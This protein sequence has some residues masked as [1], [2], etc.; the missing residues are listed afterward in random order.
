MNRRQFLK[1]ALYGAGG[2]AIGVSGFGALTKVE[3]KS[4]IATTNTEETTVFSACEMC[5][6]QCPIAVKVVN[7]KV[8]KIEGNPNDSGFGGVI[9]AR[10]NSGPSLLYDP[11]RLKKPMIRTGERGTGKYKEVSWDEAYTYIAD[12]LKVI[13]QD[14]GGESV[15]FASRKG[16]HDWFFRTIGKGIG[17]PNIFSHEATC[18]MTRSVALDSMFGVEAIAADYANAKY[19]VSIGRNWLEGIHIAQ[20]RAIMKAI[21]N[22]AKLVVLDP[23]LSVTASK[24]EWI[25]IK[26]T[27]DLAFVMAMANIII[28][29]ERYDK[30][31]VE[32]YTSGFDQWKEAVKDKTPEWAE[33]ETGIPK[34]TIIRITR[35]F[36]EAGP[37]A[38]LD[39]GWRTGLTPNDFQ[40]RRAIMSV[41]MMMGNFEVPGGYYRIK[42][43]SVTNRFPEMTG[44]AK[45]LGTINQPAFP[46]PVTSRIDGTGIKGIPGQLIPEGDGAVGQIVESILTGQPYQIKAWMVHRF[47][48]VISITESDRVIEALKKLDLLVVCDVYMTDTAMFADVILPECS[49]LERYE[50]VYDMSGLTPKY[51][52][53]QPAVELVYPDTKPAWQIYKELGEKMG[54]GKYFPYQ[55]IENYISRQLTPA[56]LS[57][58]QL[59]QKGVWTPEG[60]KPFYLRANDSQASLGNVIS[61]VSQKIEFYSEEVQHATKQGVPQYKHHPQPEEGKFRFVQGKVAVH[62]NAGTVNVPVLNELMPQNSLWIN[63]ASADKLGILDGDDIIISSGIYEHKGKAK[64]TEGIRPDTVFCYHGFGRISPELKRAFGKGINDNKLILNQIGEVGN[65]CTSMTIVTVK[66]A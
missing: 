13:Q 19:I 64:V 60:M 7:G 39:F 6:N 22:G 66:K 29:E 35:E 16:P 10:G 12:K 63:K 41:N 20:T 34:E 9:C 32:R 47:N 57:L 30:D 17:S 21:D 1:Y 44:Y 24:G 50:P 37:K 46:K 14:F 3:P 42:N 65:V 55:N 5:R 45:A 15:A 28:A 43:A 40:L 38:I 8:T 27:T 58:S 62:T 53:R 18:P 4:A 48:P 54:L 11:Q 26:G 52:L 49:Y 59:K 36:A 25:P 33:N 61:K 23:R 2:T 56:G 31:F 51:V